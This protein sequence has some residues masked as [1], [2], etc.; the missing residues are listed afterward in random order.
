MSPASIQTQAAVLKAAFNNVSALFFSS[1][2]IVELQHLATCL[3]STVVI[4]VPR[5][6]ANTT[7]S[8]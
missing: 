1:F 5:F 6:M 8:L 2:F 3:L 7:V 4:Y